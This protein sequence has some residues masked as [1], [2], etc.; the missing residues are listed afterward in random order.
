MVRDHN[1]VD[2]QTR[3]ITDGERDLILRY[4][5]PRNRVEQHRE[6]TEP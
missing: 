4:T 5:R 6:V 2:K 1:L 3:Q